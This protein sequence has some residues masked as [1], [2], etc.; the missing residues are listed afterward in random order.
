MSQWTDRI[1]NHPV[2]QNL[3]TT[4]SLLAQA[5]PLTTDNPDA[6]AARERLVAVRGLISNVLGNVDPEHVPPQVLKGIAQHVALLN[7]EVQTFVSNRNAAHLNTAN[8]HA[9]NLLPLIAT[10]PVVITPQ[11]V[12]GIRDSITSFRRSSGR[13][14]GSMRKEAAETK[15]AI[16]QNRAQSDQEVAN[17]RTKLQGIETEIQKAQIEIQN[18]KGRLDTAIA[19]FQQ[20]FSKQQEE[21]QAN[22]ADAE[23]KRT[24][25]F[26]EEIKV[27]SATMDKAFDGAKAK[28]DGLFTETSEKTDAF[29]KNLEGYKDRAQKLVHVIGNTGMVGGYQKTANTERRTARVWQVLA[30]IFF[31]GLIWFAVS[32]FS[33]TFEGQFTWSRFAARAFVAL[34]FGIAAAYCARQS[35]RHEDAEAYNRRIELELASI[36]P[37]LVGL[38]DDTQYAVKRGLAERLFGQK[39]PPKNDV[40]VSGTNADILR[41]AVESLLELIKKRG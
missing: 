37:Y 3:K 4:D 1:E 15:E 38:P 18:Q 20:Q 40:E 5:E 9:D 41:M 13:L 6:F 16:V 21:R 14:F 36:D 11:D 39:P 19:Q 32:L 17:L 25:A 23:S 7:N 24:L 2:H 8:G 35:D 27:Y 12:E 31:G 29:I 10:I 33:A 26:T 30:I 34:T 28:F 22:F